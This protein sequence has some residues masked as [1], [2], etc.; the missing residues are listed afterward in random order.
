MDKINFQNRKF[1]LREIELPEIGNVLISTTL[2]NEL[3]LNEDGKYV[4][5]KAAVIDENIFYFV[6]NKQ[7]EFSNLEL[8]DLITKEVK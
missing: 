7:I 4:S 5:D 6:D 2:L 8:V 3:L 1:K